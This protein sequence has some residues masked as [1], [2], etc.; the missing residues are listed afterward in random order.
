MIKPDTP[1]A[2]AL[3]KWAPRY[4]SIRIKI[5]YN[6][7]SYT[8]GELWCCDGA[9][10][11]QNCVSIDGIFTHTHAGLDLY[12]AVGDKVY[13]LELCELCVAD[14]VAALLERRDA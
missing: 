1:G 3:F 6:E 9:R 2:S 12:A 13:F 11:G 5:V 4:H 7:P 10:P 8:D 14:L